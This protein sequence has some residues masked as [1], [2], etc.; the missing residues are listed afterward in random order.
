M[1]DLGSESMCEAEPSLMMHR[2]ID[3]AP[4]CLHLS[5]ITQHSDP[6][7]F[8]ALLLQDAF[9]QILNP[10]IWFWLDFLQS[11]QCNESYLK[12]CQSQ[13]LISRTESFLNSQQFDFWNTIAHTMVQL[14]LCP[15]NFYFNVCKEQITSWEC[16]RYILRAHCLHGPQN[17]QF[18]LETIPSSHCRYWC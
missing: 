16:H 6:H 7:Y 3:I 13:I 9:Y 12:F 8:N 2:L 18:P 14:F 5:A 17:Q 10:S 4:C 11:I 1:I 15:R